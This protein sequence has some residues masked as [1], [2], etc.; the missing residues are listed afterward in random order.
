M[1]LITEHDEKISATRCKVPQRK[2]PYAWIS[3]SSTID[4]SVVEFWYNSTVGRQVY[5]ELDKQWYRFADNVQFISYTHV[6]RL[7][8]ISRKEAK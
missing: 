4:E 7:R 8:R 5:F 2:Q 6:Q 1:I 3:E